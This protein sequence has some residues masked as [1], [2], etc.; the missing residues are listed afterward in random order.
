MAKGFPR[1]MG[2]GMGNMNQMIKQAQKMQ[3]QMAKMQ[4]ELENKTFEAVVGGGA[5]KAVVS[6]KKELVSIN[7]D[8]AAVDP[9]DVEMLEDL[10]VAAVN[11]AMR[12]AG[13]ES[14]NQL[15]ALTGG[16]NI[17]GMF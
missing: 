13:Q 11:E 3:E 17:P 9:D 7:I 5:V 10:I 14:E 16:L 2:G 1:G 15:G 6:G 12:K 4:E 8:E